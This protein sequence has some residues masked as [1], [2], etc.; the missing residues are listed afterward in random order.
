MQFWYKL[1]CHSK[2]GRCNFMH[3]CTTQNAK[4]QQV[5]NEKEQ[6]LDKIIPIIVIILK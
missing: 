4:Y 5:W 6:E 2:N 1:W 3:E